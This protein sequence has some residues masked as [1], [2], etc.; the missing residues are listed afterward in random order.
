MVSIQPPP[1]LPSDFY[2]PADIIDRNAFSPKH[3]LKME[4]LL[5]LA[6]IMLALAVFGI[7]WKFIDWFGQLINE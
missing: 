1:P 3:H 2:V 4:V 6:M 5:G 7:L